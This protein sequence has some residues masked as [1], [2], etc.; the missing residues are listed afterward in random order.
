MVAMTIFRSVVL[1]IG[2]IACAGGPDVDAV[3]SVTSSSAADL[4][5]DGSEGQSLVGEA[6]QRC[7]NFVWVCEFTC[8]F[9]GGQNVLIAN[10][11]GV[12][13]VVQELPCSSD[14]CF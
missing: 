13:T 11:N 7:S 12:E 9:D 10:C 8:P 5:V 4:T 3:N 2:L 14:G 1:S 6:A